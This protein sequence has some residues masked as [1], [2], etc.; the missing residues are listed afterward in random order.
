MG[1]VRNEAKFPHP[2]AEGRQAAEAK[3]GPADTNLERGRVP[4]ELRFPLG[5]QGHGS[6]DEGRC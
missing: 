1:N 3:Q 2:Q 4:F 6:H 5:Q